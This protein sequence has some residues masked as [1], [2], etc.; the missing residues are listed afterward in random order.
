MILTFL[1]T[2]ANLALGKWM[3]QNQTLKHVS[4]SFERLVVSAERGSG[5]LRFCPYPVLA[6]FAVR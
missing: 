4:V 3:E 2:D 1:P 5:T 6:R